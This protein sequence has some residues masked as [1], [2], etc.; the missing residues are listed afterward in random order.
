[1]CKNF[2]LLFPL[3]EVFPK[4]PQNLYVFFSLMV[5]IL[6]FAYSHL[7]LT[8]YS[9]HFLMAFRFYF[10][11]LCYLLERIVLIFFAVGYFYYLKIVLFISLKL[12][13]A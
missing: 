6:P 3:I 9:F 10:R 11:L 5:R 7:V 12:R 8:Y 2:F 1:M 13:N 4:D